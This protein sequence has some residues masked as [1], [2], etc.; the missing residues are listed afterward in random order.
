MA[1]ER[2]DSPGSMGAPPAKIGAFR[3]PCD[4]EFEQVILD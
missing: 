4:S 1:T 3:H 2:R